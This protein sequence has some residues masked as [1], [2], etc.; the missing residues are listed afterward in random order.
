VANAVTQCGTV[1]LF[2]GFGAYSTQSV[3]KDYTKLPEHT[4]VYVSVKVFFLDTWEKENFWVVVDG[5][6]VAF[7]P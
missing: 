2:G 4:H 5:V 6:K 7:S 1:S 3:K